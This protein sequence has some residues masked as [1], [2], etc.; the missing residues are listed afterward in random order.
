MEFAWIACL[1]RYDCIINRGSIDVRDN[2]KSSKHVLT[3]LRFSWKDGTDGFTIKIKCLALNNDI[4]V[5]QQSD[6][7]GRIT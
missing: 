3:R 6:H 2:E 5:A 4:N 1:R 7:N